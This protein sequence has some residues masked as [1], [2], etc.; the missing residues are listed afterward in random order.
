MLHKP[1]NLNLVISQPMFFPWLGLFEQIKLSDIFIHY[2]DVQYPQGRSF[3]SRVQIKTPAGVSWLTAPV[4]RAES[5]S[6]INQTILVSD[7]DWRSNHLKTLKHSFSKAPFF[8]EMFD[9]AVELYSL[10]TNNLSEFNINS[11]EKISDYLGLKTKFFK[12]SDIGLNSSSSEKLLDLC[13]NYNASDYITG[14]GAINYLDYSIFEN[15]N[16]N[17][18]YMKY[19]KKVYP[20]L[21]GEFTPFVSVLDAIANL[22]KDA[23]NLL[24]SNAVY[25]RDFLNE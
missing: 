19:E 25:W 13:L 17:V 8:V 22:G 21:Y 15:N 24:C 6:I 16:I 1:E 14:L 2:D 10:P 9:L 4:S 3:I 20:Q 7:N 23:S 11:I 12:S 18:N 5:G